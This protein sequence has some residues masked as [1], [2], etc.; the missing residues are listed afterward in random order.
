MKGQRWGLWN[1]RKPVY[2]RLSR[3]SFISCFRLNQLK[4]LAGG[5]VILVQ[6][7]RYR[8]F[9]SVA[10]GYP[11]YEACHRKKLYV[12]QHYYLYIIRILQGGTGAMTT[13][14]IT[15]Y[16]FLLALDL[17]LELGKEKVVYSRT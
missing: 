1:A 17:Y 6:L 7:F 11:G 8:R 9:I 16:L 15:Q 3:V 5:I 4:P 2:H 10:Y 14:L 13:G 12:L